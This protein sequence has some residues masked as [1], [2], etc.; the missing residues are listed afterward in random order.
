MAGR[1]G[2]GVITES[3]SSSAGVEGVC[4]PGEDVDGSEGLAWAATWISFFGVELSCLQVATIPIHCSTLSP[5]LTLTMLVPLWT[6]VQRFLTRILE[7]LRI[8]M[9][10]AL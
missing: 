2:L 6:L 9:F 7:A 8:S 4:T 3:W 10:Q 1:K 5:V